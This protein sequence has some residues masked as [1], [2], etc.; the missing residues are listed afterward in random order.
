[1]C[2]CKTGFVLDFFYYVCTGKDTHIDIVEKL[3]VSGSVVST[4]MEP[5]LGLVHTLYVDNW[6]TSLYLFQ[7]LH[8][9]KTGAV[10]TCKADRKHMAKF[11]SKMKTGE[12][13]CKESPLQ[14]RI[15]WIK[16]IF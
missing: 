7:F 14:L 6:Y 10:G 15:G 11:P 8:N 12:Y 9:N 4:L 16:E 1:M 3:G 13:M 2:D 5:Y